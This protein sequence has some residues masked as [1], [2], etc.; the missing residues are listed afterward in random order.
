[1]YKTLCDKNYFAI[2]G[3]IVDS[4]KIYE[5]KEAQEKL[6]KILQDI[7]NKYYSDI[8]A[9]FAISLGDEF[10]GLL[11]NGKNIIKII[12]EIQMTMM[13]IE[14]RFGI[15]IGGISTEINLERSVEVDGPAYNRARKMIDEIEM[16]KKQ[17]T[18]PK[19]NIMICSDEKNY[20]VD[21]LLNSILSVCSALRSK[22]TDRQKE[23]IATYLLNEGNQYKVADILKIGQSSVNKGL[24]NAEFYS[25]KTAMD[26]V[27]NFLSRRDYIE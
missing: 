19:Y 2:I 8:S 25:Y 13:P 27:S 20:E 22:W 1:M 14:V 11:N 18:E 15:G 12:L 5:R 26:T 6:K 3:D 4:K 23:I 17:Y 7:N 21:K 24:N 10:Q 9:K 16:K